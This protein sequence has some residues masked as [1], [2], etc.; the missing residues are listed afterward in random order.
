MMSRLPAE[1]GSQLSKQATQRAL[2]LL[3]T[4]KFESANRYKVRSAEVPMR[5]EPR[6]GGDRQASQSSSRRAFIAQ[7]T[8]HSYEVG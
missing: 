8:G 2:I 7:F 5:K 3:K 1:F 6:D 4:R